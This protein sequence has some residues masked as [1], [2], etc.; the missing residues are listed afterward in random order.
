MGISFSLDDA[1]WLAHLLQPAGATPPSIGESSV[2]LS[3]FLFTL[4]RNYYPRYSQ[5]G[6]R[7]REVIETYAGRHGSELDLL[8]EL[9]RYFQ[10]IPWIALLVPGGF[11]YELDRILTD[12]STLEEL[13]GVRDEDPGLILQIDGTFNPHEIRLTNVFPAFRVALENATRWPGV[14]LWSG[15]DA[16]F[17]PLPRHAARLREALHWVFSHLATMFDRPNLAAFRVQY[18][19][20]VDSARTVQSRLNIL[21]LS[22]LHLGSKAA[23]MRLPRVKTLIRSTVEDLGEDDPVVP[24][25]TGD[26]MDTPSQENLDELRSFSEFLHSLGVDDPILLLGNHDVRDDGWLAP[27][28][29]HAV[30]IE[31]DRV[32]WKDGP[33]V[34]LASFN[35]VVGGNLARG[36]IGEREFADVGDALD[37]DR[38]KARSYAVVALLHHHPVPVRVPSWYRR[39]WYER[40]LGSEFDQTED[41]VDAQLFLKWIQSR[42]ITAVLHGHKHIPRFTV[43]EGISII[44]CGSTVGKVDTVESGETYVSMNVV[45]VD[46][47]TGELSCRL[48]SERIPGGGFESDEVYE[49]V[50][51]QQLL[52]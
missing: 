41:L 38:E 24:V 7:I 39:S 2:R 9:R 28:H 23:R 49:I 44:G 5:R 33:R 18:L 46:Q 4:G 15:Q 50:G 1:N 42:R 47:A 8:E 32:V 27:I 16:T 20:E 36:S 6:N 10:E 29:E 26:L 30:H 11:D 37:R 12:S 52:R 34:A 3:N 48:R 45:T 22:D 21:H 17:L 43:H 13:V 25:V 19:K 14:L 51:R 40:L 35:S 31:R